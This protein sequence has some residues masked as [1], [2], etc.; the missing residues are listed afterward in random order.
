MRFL[1]SALAY[2]AGHR[3][4]P[5][6]ENEFPQHVPMTLP[7]ILGAVAHQRHP[8][9]SRQLLNQPKRELLAVVLNC[10]VALV[11]RTIEEKLRS[12]VPCKLRPRHLATLARA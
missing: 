1:A 12:I 4:H 11:D 5:I 8:T 6:A 7:L 2:E 3:L 9:A 10:S